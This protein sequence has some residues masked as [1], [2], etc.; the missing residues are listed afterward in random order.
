MKTK[1]IV[2]LLLAIAM[3]LSALPF[4]GITASAYQGGDFY[5]RLLADGTAVITSYY[6]DYAEYIIIPSEI[7]GYTVT[8]I[9]DSAFAWN[10][11]LVGIELPDTL[12]SIGSS[13]FF[14]C[15]SL[16]LVDIPDSVMSI[17]DSTF[18][19]CYNL[20]SIGVGTG[21]KYY[22]SQDG[23]L[24]DKN[25]TSI[26]QYPIGNEKTTYII[27]DGVTS[28]GNN[29]FYDSS[30][31]TVKIPDSVTRIGDSAFACC[32]MLTSVII[33]NSITSIGYGAFSYCL[34]LTSVEIP[35]SVTSIGEMAFGKCDS[36][37]SITVGTGNLCYSSQN[38]V[39]FD[40]DKTSLI[41]YPIGN[42][43]T[44]YTIPSSV[45]DIYNY[46]F[47]S[48]SLTKVTMYNGITIIGTGA[49]WDCDSLKDVYYNGSSLQWNK[50]TIGD[51]N[52][53]LKNATIHYNYS[54]ET[55]LSTPKISSVE[56]TS[57]GVKITWG[58]ISGAEKYRVYYKT[59]SG[60]WTKIADTTAT[61]YT[62]TKAAS[63]T[64]YTFTIRCVDKDGKNF[65]SDYDKTGK[66]ITY[67][68]AP[69]LS[70]VEN[71]ATGIKIIWAKS[72]GAAKYR[73]YYKTS[74][75][76]W[77]KITDTTSTSYTWTGAKSG[78]K[79][80]FTVRCI[81]SDGKSFTSSFDST[82]KTITYVAAPKLSSV[83]N[84]A[85]GVKITWEK[86]TGAAKYRVYYKSADGWTKIADTTS[87]SYTW[88]G[89]KSGTKYT[90]TVRCIT[91]DG[92]SFTSSFDSTGKTITYVAT[93]KLSAVENTA[94]GVKITWEK[95]T[96][97]AKYRVYY[98]S[99]NGWTKIA[100]TT[101]T[102]YTWTGAKSGTKYTFT[103]RCIS[104]DTKSFTSSFDSTGKS[105][106]YIAAP[107][108][109]SLTNTATGVEIKW[110]KVT[111]AVNYKVYR[112]TGNESWTAIGTTTG[113]NFVDKTAK[114]GTKYTYTV[115]CIS[116]DGKS[117]T[118]GYDST[119]KSI[120]RN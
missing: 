103:V 35:N 17:G 34:S 7:D 33:P 54:T 12:T 74:G 71:T 56:N 31:K 8:G 100:D 69:N 5:Y 37:T 27:P 86:S 99:A 32:S 114:K 66:S 84:V 109:S 91:S 11:S 57:I 83:E 19:S 41:Q 115:R 104:S 49:F 51:S 10:D 61:N 77:T 47:Y 101:S 73:V 24:F 1:K 113:T 30:L 117:F 46:A 20:I 120:T 107:K 63:G 38:G 70:A 29:A 25:K 112:K 4:A 44:S 116:E 39:L 65:T 87:T 96:G 42:E 59:E 18:G 111:G 2:S 89:A 58:K 72:T 81:T 40:N 95:S 88:T 15:E 21:N 106:T 6:D 93:P 110:G 108:I 79:Y 52:D 102:S 67:I 53:Y 105:I 118:S 16:T 80:T 90:F 82:G 22:S 23:V 75:G 45:T 119:G 85:T 14:G 76:S 60:S 97:A 26:V 9:G 62:W 28:I 94:T 50:I 3:L 36:L 55:T 13:A 68:A 64:K 78:T 48:A 92:K 98:K 43:S